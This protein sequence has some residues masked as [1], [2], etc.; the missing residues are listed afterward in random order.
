M[1]DVLV[2]LAAIVAG[3]LLYLLTRRA[4]RPQLIG[5]S[6]KEI[7]RRWNEVAELMAVKKEMNYRLAVIEADK[8]LDH[9]LR[10]L[11]FQGETMGDRLKIASYR[12]PHLKKVVWAHRVRNQVVHEA[13]H[14]LRY[15]ETRLVL[16]LY[17]KALQSL[18]VL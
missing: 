8:L 11:N 18:R 2:L 6:I 1:G 7:A 16:K 15:G 17:K 10:A 5:L 4:G 3:A 14:H 9:V 13:N 12:F